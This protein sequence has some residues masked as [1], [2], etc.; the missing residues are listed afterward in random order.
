MNGL[1]AICDKVNQDIMIILQECPF[2]LEIALIASM[3]F[4]LVWNSHLAIYLIIL[5]SIF[6]MCSKWNKESYLPI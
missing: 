6:L 4:D 2:D 3:R 1:N 5:G